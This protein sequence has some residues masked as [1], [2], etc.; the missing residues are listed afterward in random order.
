KAPSLADK[1][2]D[3]V[4]KSISFKEKILKKRFKVALDSCNASGSHITPKL[5]KMLGC[6]INGLYITPDGKFPH[7]PE[8]NAAN[9]KEMTRFMKKRKLDVGF[10]QDSDADR[11]AV[12][13]E[14]GNF[15]SEEHTLALAVYYI[16]SIYDKTS[17]FKK[18]NRSVVVNL[19]TSRMIDDV[20]KI[21]NAKV[22]RTP[23][24]EANVAAKALSTK[25]V[26]AG[27]GNGGVI[28]PF[29][30]NGRDSL[31]GIALILD[32]MAHSEEKISSLLNK[33]PAYTMFK[34]KFNIENVNIK[35]V[36]NNIKKTYRSGKTDER[37][38]IKIDFKDHWFHIRLS[39]TEPIVRLVIEAKTR[40]ILNKAHAELKKFF[41]QQ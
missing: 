10:A 32:Y 41:T 23:V 6:E 34:T 38:G 15:L 37:D 7:R 19:S 18:Y 16:L 9:L 20:A 12:F 30:N 5:L 31:T 39:N 24:G 4:L 33:I 11:L 35:K 26:I 27:E 22:F 14:K 3:R 1:H 29:V 25:S 8:P 40:G 13:D 17:K 36:L 28:L 21:F 2:L